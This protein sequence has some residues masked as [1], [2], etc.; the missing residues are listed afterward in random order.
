MRIA[1]CWRFS[2]ARASLLWCC[3]RRDASES[4]H[5]TSIFDWHSSRGRVTHVGRGVHRFTF[6]SVSLC[7]PSILKAL[8]GDHR[9]ELARAKES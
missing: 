2:H 3:C 4:W 7:S 1:G 9:V 5:K 6:E 8:A